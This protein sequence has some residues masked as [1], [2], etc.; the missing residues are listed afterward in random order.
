MGILARKM[1]E[2]A[3]NLYRL[4]F[5]KIKKFKI[6]IKKN[7]I[8]KSGAYIRNAEFEGRN[9]LG[10]N[11]SFVNGRMGYGSYINRDGDITETDIGRYSSIGANVSTVV[12]RHPIEK[13]LAMHPAFTDPDPVFGFSFA[14]KKTFAENNGRI[15]I[16][17]DVWI[18][19]HVKILDGVKIADG[20]VI[21][22]GAVVTKDI[23]PYA[24]AAGV[25]ARVIKYRFDEK[26]VEKL[27]RL[28]W[29][30]K[31]ES[32]IRTNIDGFEDAKLLL[33]KL[34]E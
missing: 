5:L 9:F 15:S 2:A 10:R 8:F 16:G 26:T 30:D 21:G 4:T 12:G 7:C 34:G 20:A 18:G 33:D 27:L 3:G 19:N 31:E 25:P 11:T 13:Q 1:S 6:E 29:W 14:K 23:P 24:V 17:N 32:W 22:A 28:K